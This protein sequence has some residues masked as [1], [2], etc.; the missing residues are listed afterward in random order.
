MDLSREEQSKLIE[1][2]MIFGYGPRICIGKEYVVSG[3][4][5]A[6]FR[7]AMMELRLLL[8][9]L[10]LKYETW[11]GVPDKPGKWDEEMKPQDSIALLPR[12]GKCVLKFKS[13]V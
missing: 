5:W 7:M 12:N 3:G 10:I 4:A 13:R 2:T 11:S 6:D 1:R 8:S 9:A